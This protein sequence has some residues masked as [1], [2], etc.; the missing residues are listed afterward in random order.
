[1]KLK[2]TRSDSIETIRA[3][4]ENQDG[5]AAWFEPAAMKFF[6]TRFVGRAQTL[7]LAN[8]ERV[9][10]FITSEAPNADAARRFTVRKF[11]WKERQFSTIGPFQAHATKEAA[12]A[13]IKAE[14]ATYA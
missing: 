2:N 8:Q 6:R 13:F 7:E 9:S 11:N 10:Y 12:R 4:Y 3:Y 1:M 5:V 14:I